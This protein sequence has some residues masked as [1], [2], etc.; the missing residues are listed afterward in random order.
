MKKPQIKIIKDGP[1][2]VSNLPLIKQKIQTDN[3]G[4]PTKYVKIKD[5]KTEDKYYLCRCGNSKNKP[6]C[7]S[8]HKK[9]NF[10]GK[11]TAKRKPYLEQADRVDGNDLF[12]TDAFA[13]CSGAGFCHARQGNTWDLIKDEN[14]ALRK[15]AIKQCADCS[16]GRLVAWDKKTNKPI[17]PKFKPSISILYE[18]WKKVGSSIWVKGGVPIISSDNYKYEIRNRVTLCRCGRSMN[19]PFCDATHRVDEF[20]DTE[21]DKK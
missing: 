6:F 1:Y 12:L 17:E 20:I 4:H 2:E 19:M 8:T 5:Y 21:E 13:F 16:S 3:Q 11:E 18:P 9:I 7:D 14:P 15:I 10:N